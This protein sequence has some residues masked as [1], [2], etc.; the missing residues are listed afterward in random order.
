MCPE[1]R[2]ARVSTTHP[3]GAGRGAARLVR[4]LRDRGRESRGVLRGWALP[5]TLTVE[6]IGARSAPPFCAPVQRAERR[7][8]AWANGDDDFRHAPICPAVSPPRDATAPLEEV[9]RR[10]TWQ[11]WIILRSPSTYTSPSPTPGRWPTERRTAACSI[12][13]WATPA[14]SSAPCCRFAGGKS[15]TT[16]SW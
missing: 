4:Q 1:T 16:A 10:H 12:M 14:T 2:V 15:P 7:S 8:G 3:R 9:V 5:L 6:V 11:R 13:S